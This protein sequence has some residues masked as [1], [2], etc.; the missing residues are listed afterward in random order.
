MANGNN[1]Y[2]SSGLDSFSDGLVGNQFT[3]GSSQFTLGNF[4]ISVSVTDKQNTE[5]SLGNFSKPITL[6]TINLQNPDQTKVLANNQLKAFV[7]YDPQKITDFTLYGSLAERM[8]VATQSIVKNF[9]AGLSVEKVRAD[10][11]TGLTATNILYDAFDKETTLNVNVLQIKNPFAIE[12]TTIGNLF[13]TGSTD[14]VNEIRNFT[15][16]FGKYSL[17]IGSN[18]YPITDITPAPSNV[19]GSLVISVD[20]NPFSATTSASTFTSKEFIIRP[21]TLNTEETFDELGDIEQILLNRESIPLYT[22]KFDMLRESNT[23]ALIK[24]SKSIT[25]PLTD[26]WNILIDGFSFTTYLNSLND[27][28]ITYD[29]YKTN[30]ISRF[31]TTGALKEFDTEDQAFEKVLQIYG[32]SF[33]EV[34]KYIDGLAYMTNVSYD[35]IHNVP[36]TLLKNLAQMLGWGTPNSIAQVDLM[37]ALFSRGG[38]QEFAGVATNKTPSELNIELY[39]KILVNTAYLFKSKGTRKSIEFLLRLIGAP[40]GLIEFNEHVYLAGNRIN[41]DKFNKKLDSFSGGT[42]TENV[43]VRNQYFSEVPP[44]QG[45]IPIT[46]TGYTYGVSAVTRQVTAIREEYPVGKDGYPIP[47]TFSKDGYF[48]AGAGWFE[49]TPEHKSSRI[50]DEKKSVFTGDSP[51]VVT[52]FA[53]FTYGEKYLDYL[54]KF[55]DMNEG[56][57]LSRTVD[58]KKSWVISEKRKQDESFVNLQNRVSILRGRGTKY[59]AHTDRQILNVKNVDLFLNIGQGLTWDVWNTSNKFGCL[60]GLKP[61][62]DLNPLYPS[63]PVGPDWTPI[64]IDASKL[65]FFEFAESFWKI[66]VNV[67]NRQTIDDGHGGGYPTLQMVYLDY[68]NSK[69]VCGIPNN[70]YTYEK[71]LEF[72]DN[73]GDYWV[74]LVEQMIPATTIWQG[75]TKIEN[76]AFHRYKYAYKHEPVCDDLECL[77]SWVECVGPRFEEVLVNGHLASNSIAF[78]GAGWFNKITLNGDSY[79]GPIYYSSTTISDIPTTDLWLNNMVNIL[80]GITGECFSYYVFDDTTTGI[81]SIDNPRTIVVQGCCSGGTDM[82]GV[83]GPTPGTFLAEACLNLNG[84]YASI[85]SKK[86]DIYA[87]YDTTSTPGDTMFAAKASID[88]FSDSMRTTGWSGKTYHIPLFGDLAANERWLGWSSYPADGHAIRTSSIAPDTCSPCWSN[89]GNQYFLGNPRK[90]CEPENGG[91]AVWPDEVPNANMPPNGN[92]G[93]GSHGLWTGGSKDVIIINFV[94]ESDTSYY[95][96]DNAGIFNTIGATPNQGPP[97]PGAQGPQWG[98]AGAPTAEP[99]MGSVADWNRSGVA[100]PTAAYTTDFNNFMAAHATFDYFAGLMYPM[101]IDNLPQRMDMNLHVYGAMETGWCT[102]C[103]FTN[104]PTDTCFQYNLSGGTT[105]TGHTPYREWSV[106]DNYTGNTVCQWTSKT[107]DTCSLNPGVTGFTAYTY[108]SPCVELLKENG[109]VL[110]AGGTLSAITTSNPYTSVSGTNVHTGYMGPGL[111]NFGWDWKPKGVPESCHNNERLIRNCSNSQYGI[112]DLGY[113]SPC[114][115]GCVG[116]PG[117]SPNIYRGQLSCNDHTHT[118]YNQ[119][120]GSP[121][122]GPWTSPGAPNGIFLSVNESEFFTGDE[123]NNDLLEFLKGDTTLSI[124]DFE[125]CEAI[126]TQPCEPKNY[127]QWYVDESYNLGQI[128]QYGRECYKSLISG[129]TA[130]PTIG[131]ITNYTGNTICG[132]FSG[133]GYTQTWENL[134]ISPL[135]F[136][137]GNNFRP[138]EDCTDLVEI[139]DVPQF[140]GTGFTTNPVVFKDGIYNIGGKDCFDSSYRVGDDFLDPCNC[141]T[142]VMSAD[143]QLFGVFADGVED[144][145]SVNPGTSSL[146]FFNSDT[147]VCCGAD[148]KNAG[149][150]YLL[151]P[152]YYE[153]VASACTYEVKMCAITEP[154]NW[155]ICNMQDSFSGAVAYRCWSPCDIGLLESTGRP[156]TPSVISNTS[157][158]WI[159]PNGPY[160]GGHSRYLDMGNTMGGA[161]TRSSTVMNSPGNLNRCICKNSDWKSVMYDAMNGLSMLFPDSINDFKIDGTAR[162]QTSMPYITKSLK[163]Q[164]IGKIKAD[165][166]GMVTPCCI[167]DKMEIINHIY[168]DSTYLGM[169]KWEI[170]LSETTELYLYRMHRETLDRCFLRIPKEYVTFSSYNSS[171]DNPTMDLLNPLV[172]TN[173]EIVIELAPSKTKDFFGLYQ[174]SGALGAT[175]MTH[176]AYWGNS[177]SGDL[178]TFQDLENIFTNFS[179]DGNRKYGYQIEINL[180]CNGLPADA[181]EF[182][183]TIVDYGGIN[184]ID[185]DIPSGKPCP[186][187]VLAPILELKPLDGTK[188]EIKNEISSLMNSSLTQLAGEGGLLEFNY[189][190]YFNRYHPSVD[191][192]DYEIVDGNIY[193]VLNDAPYKS[194]IELPYNHSSINVIVDTTTKI[195]TRTS[196]MYTDNQGYEKVKL[197]W[198]STIVQ[199]YP[200][201]TTQ[202]FFRNQAVRDGFEYSLTSK[203]IGNVESYSLYNPSYTTTLGAGNDERSSSKTQ[204]VPSLATEL[205]FSLSAATVGTNTPTNSFHQNF[206]KYKNLNDWVERSLGNDVFSNSYANYRRDGKLDYFEIRKDYTTALGID[207]NGNNLY[208]PLQSLNVEMLATTYGDWKTFRTQHN[209]LSGLTTQY[210]GYTNLGIY[211]SGSTNNTLNSDLTFDLVYNFSG[212][213]GTTV[214]PMNGPTASGAILQG[215]QN[216]INAACVK[217]EVLSDNGGPL[218][219]QVN[220]DNDYIHYKILTTG[221]YRFQYQGAL[222]FDYYDTGWCEYL[223]NY[224]KIYTNYSYPSNDYHYKN[225]VNSSILYAGGGIDVT[226]QEGYDS[227]PFTN[228][229]PYFRVTPS[230]GFSQYR[231]I[232]H[233]KA[234]IWIERKLSGSTSAIT[235]TQYVVGNNPQVCPTADKFLTL[236][237]TPGDL[238]SDTYNISGTTCGYPVVSGQVG[239]VFSKICDVNL[240]TKCIKLN[241]GDEIRLKHSVNWSSSTKLSGTTSLNLRLGTKT[242]NDE[243]RYPWYRV[244]VDACNTKKQSVGLVWDVDNYG[245]DLVWWNK[246]VKYKG[247]ER[248]SLFVTTMF[249]NEPLIYSPPI[250][251]KKD[252]FNLTYLDVS[253][254]YRGKFELG[255]AKGQ[256]S[257][258]NETLLNGGFTDALQ[259]YGTKPFTY[260][261]MTTYWTMPRFEQFVGETPAFPNYQHTYLVETIFQIKGTSNKFSHM[262]YYKDNPDT[263]INYFNGT[264][265]FGNPGA[266]GT[267]RDYIVQNRNQTERKMYFSLSDLIIDGE[268]ITIRTN[269]YNLYN[270]VEAQEEYT[271]ICECRVK[272]EGKVIADKKLNCKNNKLCGR[273]C[274]EFC[275]AVRPNQLMVGKLKS[276]GINTPIGRNTIAG[277]NRY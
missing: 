202:V 67:K 162:V 133:S 243:T 147:K 125:Y 181:I 17:F 170:E 103:I 240:D 234:D 110:A 83:N 275:K 203:Q 82:W 188:T 6:D 173:T 148:T 145:K 186:T 184:T 26:K 134:S 256:S 55:P 50:V 208:T 48:Q 146:L 214:I 15:K 233:L 122:T 81:P 164:V 249:E 152:Y 216:T 246:G 199:A 140:S 153:W 236:D 212:F 179:L 274:Q 266:V 178:M 121:C 61:L 88:T 222:T 248:G 167:G 90:F 217:P 42:Y 91:F 127:N 229:S 57:D 130:Q 102:G 65:S 49:R 131:A 29:S 237:V 213:T 16:E 95:T 161:S 187:N 244:T 142:T 227:N 228:I 70:Q 18:E 223:R 159:R 160:G 3:D 158:P 54:R 262:V 165:T 247:K 172:A 180:I 268:P 225:L 171:L 252:I 76:S 196:L 105:I 51:S 5:F 8:K 198:F 114:Y 239:H 112:G 129:N 137:G 265:L 201:H 36:D 191:T 37:D 151:E 30:L 120:V 73:M 144:R 157:Y 38:K 235:L 9:P 251:N 24:S 19:S 269:E 89:A 258:W 238:I 77:G 138:R 176:P 210:T 52:Q 189:Q 207:E 13:F 230:F 267:G 192:E 35:K 43:P 84:V 14:G 28:A 58:N 97:T 68:L 154:F 245:P 4:G 224:Y 190:Q 132:F 205:N 250:N 33:D 34:K 66:H 139:P 204:V 44:T 261:G 101:T 93:Q 200:N 218:Y 241:A 7:N 197:N 11:L 219:K 263:T 74:R 232:D 175:F 123:F 195:A 100:Q 150:S 56:Y 126:C 98:F 116:Y 109:T 92:F 231:G 149:Q 99:P 62:V 255:I 59:Y 177:S 71:M 155:S 113:G 135:S 104:N 128:V 79:T 85:A 174:L 221:E 86:T 169:R 257:R 75:G 193:A 23:G 21:N 166:I 143:T 259:P 206:V 163:Q 253:K 185:N 182:N 226:T 211:N 46:I 47:P 40:Q 107:G 136:D 168:S 264:T 118:E 111:K 115:Q 25:W 64:Q 141:D 183:D 78:S 117:G 209:Q 10:F 124:G 276:L 87:F 72:V 272:N 39:R 215:A 53:P 156:A 12:F 273:K 106:Q 194:G 119:R 254:K 1:I 2:A 96:T 22:A 80:S 271:S 242:I 94:D 220:I 260:N 60:Y 20:G 32:R 270:S 27:I 45:V 63:P 277:N 69:S 31:L 41:V 108:M